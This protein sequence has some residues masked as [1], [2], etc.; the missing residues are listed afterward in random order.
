MAPRVDLTGAQVEG[1]TVIQ[2]AAAQ[3]R[4][5]FWTAT[6]D[7][8]GIVTDL[9]HVTLK[10]AADGK[11]T[12]P[13]CTTCVPADE[14]R[15]I[16]HGM[17][18]A[19][20]HGHLIGT[21]CPDAAARPELPEPN[22]LLEVTLDDSPPVSLSYAAS[23]EGDPFWKS[24]EGFVADI[25]T[26]VLTWMQFDEHD[27]PDFQPVAYT[28]HPADVLPDS[29]YQKA[30]AAECS[31]SSTAG[32]GGASQ[33][34]T[35][36]SSASSEPAPDA[37]SSK[38]ST[39][40]IEPASHLADA[41]TGAVVTHGRVDRLGEP[42]DVLDVIRAAMHGRARNHQSQP[43]PSQIGG[44]ERRL[45][46]HLA[47]GQGNSARSDDAWR[48]EVGTAVH[49]WLDQ[50]FSEDIGTRRGRWLSDIAVTA[51]IAGRLDL[52]DLDTHTV[53]D[54]KVS[55]KATRDKAARGEISEKYQTQLDLYGLGMLVAGYVVE[56]VALLFLPAA[57]SLDEAVWYSRPFDL[58]RALDA[59]AR[60]DRIAAMLTVADP[61]HVLA[62]LPTSEDY[63][64]SCPA[65]G[66]H[67]KGAEAAWIPGG[68][69]DST[70]PAYD[71]AVK[72][73]S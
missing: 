43:G 41:E 46:H 23:T 14:R 49:A 48:P 30:K 57:G 27:A 60:R 35:P 9:P 34:P 20:G 50:M 2:K 63:C 64:A 68:L 52:F 39:A 4:V 29:A 66:A 45:G 21:P 13:A 70:W 71:A 44:C 17:H 25:V 51:P 7:A 55:G 61:A 11:G 62:S 73:A 24:V 22:R 5:P 19:C 28:G 38:R 32:A 15:N 47:F 16:D 40:E 59:V 54:F 67:C 53:I 37:T 18:L 65:L 6:H 26:P 58:Q 33:S 10:K 8:C 56:R 12:L 3:N 72:A 31:A 69:P 36:R 42:Q 1:W